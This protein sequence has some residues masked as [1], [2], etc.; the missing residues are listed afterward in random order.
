MHIH[1]HVHRQLTSLA[2]WRFS[3]P[4]TI[5][6]AYS[7]CT[8]SFITSILSCWANLRRIKIRATYNWRGLWM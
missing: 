5:Y 4:S 1:I 8:K 2:N 6:L 7:V 3:T